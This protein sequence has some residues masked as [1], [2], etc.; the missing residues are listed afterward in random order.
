[1]KTEYEVPEELKKL[2]DKLEAYTKLRDKFIKLPLG[3][4]KARK[5]AEDAE[6]NNRLFW[7][8]ILQIYPEL[9]GKN[10]KYSCGTFKVI[11]KDEDTERQNHLTN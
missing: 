2:I 9:T 8:G 6:Y 4:K 7:E 10:M 5:C 3:F 11:V 1:M